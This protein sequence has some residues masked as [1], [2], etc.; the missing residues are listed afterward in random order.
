[1]GAQSS[2]PHLCDLAGRPPPK[3]LPPSPPPTSTLSMPAGSSLPG[4]SAVS[5]RRSWV[6]AAT[7]SGAPASR[8]ARGHA[9]GRS[10]PELSAGTVTGRARVRG[11]RSD[12]AA[13][14]PA[15]KGVSAVGSAP[16]APGGHPPICSASVPSASPDAM[17]RTCTRA[18]SW[19]RM[20]SAARASPDRA[21]VRWAS[22]AARA[23][24]ASAGGASAGPGLCPPA[25]TH[26][27]CTRGTADVG[28][29]AGE[30][31]LRSSAPT[32]SS[33]TTESTPHTSTTSFSLGSAPVWA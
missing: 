10:R 27:A 22:A 28:G 9:A 26:S 3:A 14:T 5:S 30:R 4:A 24:A 7:C 19:R 23:R 16:G 2:Q 1:M 31:P 17:S 12:R 18:T 32:P 11:A 29:W 8:D 20:C 15:A 13:A 21:A 25:R 6:P 33:G